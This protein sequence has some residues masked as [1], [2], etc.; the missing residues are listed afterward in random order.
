V[1][2]RWRPA[3]EKNLDSIEI[4]PRYLRRI[5]EDEGLLE[6]EPLSVELGGSQ[7]IRDMERRVELLTIDPRRCRL[8]HRLVLTGRRDSECRLAASESTG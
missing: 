7:D 5:A 4:E 2:R 1:L 3:L 6:A 8:G